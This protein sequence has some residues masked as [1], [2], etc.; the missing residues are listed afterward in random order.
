MVQFYDIMHEECN[1]IL[2][3][4]IKLDESEI[5]K[6]Q[7]M[8][9][10]SL[11]LMNRVVDPRVTPKDSKYFSVQLEDDIWWLAAFE[12]EKEDHA[13]LKAFFST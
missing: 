10:V 9:R 5:V 2:K 4:V 1:G 3:F 12:V 6:G 11:T 8:E 7:K 13:I